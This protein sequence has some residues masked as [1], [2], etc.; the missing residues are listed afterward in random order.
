MTASLYEQLKYLRPFAAEYVSELSSTVCPCHGRK[1]TIRFYCWLKFPSSGG[2]KIQSRDT[3]SIFVHWNHVIITYKA[4]RYTLYV[5]ALLWKCHL[6][7]YINV[8]NR[9]FQSEGVFQ[10]VPFVLWQ[11]GVVVVVRTFTWRARGMA[12]ACFWTAS[13]PVNINISR[14]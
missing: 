1:I 6:F 9:V 8:C 12:T 13:A 5:I 7:K 4:R 2:P 14:N 3:I 11:W 10:Y